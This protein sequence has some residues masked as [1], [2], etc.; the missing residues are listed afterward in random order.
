MFT[1]DYDDYN[2]LVM[3]CWIKSAWKFAYENNIYINEK[4]T[5]NVIL[6]CLNVVFIMEA[7]INLQH[8]SKS[9]LKHI[10]RCRLHLQVTT[11]ADITTACRRHFSHSAYHCNFD[12]TIQHHYDWPVQTRPYGYAT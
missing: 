8:Y 9:E 3:I 2:A 1:L 11:L 4:V 7:I 10:N 5:D 12:S 6:Q